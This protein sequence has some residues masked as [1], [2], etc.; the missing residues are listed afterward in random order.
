MRSPH[1]FHIHFI[2]WTG[3]L[4]RTKHLII[5]ICMILKLIF[6]LLHQLRKIV[7]T[8]FNPFHPNNQST[9]INGVQETVKYR[10]H[11][12]RNPVL[13]RIKTK[14]INICAA[15]AI[16]TGKPRIQK[17]WSLLAYSSQDRKN[18]FPASP[19]QRQS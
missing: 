10:S 19:C 8:D 6:I 12:L 13:I 18:R 16:Q 9:R 4:I 3:L 14:D 2:W 11:H 5:L 15:H 7:F 1:T 17:I